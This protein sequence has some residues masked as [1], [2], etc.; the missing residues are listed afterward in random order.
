MTLSWEPPV[1][2][3]GSPVTGYY[4]ERKQGYSDRWIRCNKV[5]QKDTTYT[6]KDLVEG[7]TYEY[8]VMA[9]NAAGIGKPS[10]TTGVFTAKNPYDKPGKP[11]QPDVKLDDKGNAELSWAA[12]E[13]DGKSPITNYVIE[14][15]GPRDMRW[16]P[17]NETEKVPDT[18]YTVPNLKEGEDYE[19]RVSAQ[20][21]AGVGP[22]SQ[23]SKPVKYGEKPFLKRS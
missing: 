13:D 2:N 22:P 15:K 3:G 12:P 19:F 9:E 18:R 7:N 10:E 1:N 17:V 23:P 8:R 16:K 11:G 5:P 4:I 14:K 20:N 6:S 21:K